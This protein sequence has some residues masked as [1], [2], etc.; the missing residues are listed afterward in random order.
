MGRRRDS[1]WVYQGLQVECLLPF[2]R[3]GLFYI[4]IPKRLFN[5]MFFVLVWPIP[6]ILLPRKKKPSQLYFQLENKKQKCFFNNEMPTAEI[7]EL[8]SHGQ[9]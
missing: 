2:M 1:F 8:L 9:G 3:F 5:C 4:V 7:N 6:V